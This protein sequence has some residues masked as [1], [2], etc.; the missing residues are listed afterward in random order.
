MKDLCKAAACHQAFIKYIRERNSSNGKEN[1]QEWER[2]LVITPAY[3]P[4]KIHRNVRGVH[5]KE[6]AIWRLNK[7]REKPNIFV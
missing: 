3:M 7:N 1:E 4:P 5:D 2:Q 6:Y